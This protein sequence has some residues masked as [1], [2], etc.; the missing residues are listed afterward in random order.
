[1]LPSDPWLWSETFARMP[2]RGASLLLRETW[3]GTR[4]T[5]PQDPVIGGLVVALYGVALYGVALYGVALYGVALYGVVLYGVALY[6]VALHGVVLC[7]F[8][9]PVCHKAR[10]WKELGDVPKAAFVSQGRG[11]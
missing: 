4:L 11:D 1:M 2:T 9:V 10:N 5:R 6:G 3:G 8:E 7:R